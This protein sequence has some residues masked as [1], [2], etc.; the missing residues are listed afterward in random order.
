MSASAYGQIDHYMN[1][2]CMTINLVAS[3]SKYMDDN[4]SVMIQHTLKNE[5]IYEEE[6]L[7]IWHEE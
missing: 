7:W 4:P 5:L 1:Q 2:Q 6:K 3:E